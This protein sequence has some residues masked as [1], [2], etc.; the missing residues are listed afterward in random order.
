MPPRGSSLAVVFCPRL[1][2]RRVRGAHTQ[3]Q[4]GSPASLTGLDVGHTT[5]HLW[6]LFTCLPKLFFPCSETSAKKKMV[7]EVPVKKVVMFY[8]HIND[9]KILHY[10]QY[11]SKTA[12]YQMKDVPY[13][14]LSTKT[15]FT[16][17]F[18]HICFRGFSVILNCKSIIYPAASFWRGD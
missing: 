3:S 12:H 15:L 4:P 11:L 5:V 17:S 18:F 7:S 13:L 6:V 10:E 8:P 16:E 9:S 14:F 2:R 1:W